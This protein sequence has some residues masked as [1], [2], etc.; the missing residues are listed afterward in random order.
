MI[1]RIACLLHHNQGS[2]KNSLDHNHWLMIDMDRILYLGYLGHWSQLTSLLAVL[3]SFFVPV[4]NW[5][6]LQVLH[7]LKDC[8][9]QNIPWLAAVV[10][11]FSVFYFYT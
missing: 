2:S 11:V 4:V 5:N 1:L 10:G 9:V 8:I 3:T 7:C 6:Y